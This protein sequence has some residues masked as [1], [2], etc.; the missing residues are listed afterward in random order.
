M[1]RLSIILI[2]SATSMAFAKAPVEDEV[3]QG[4]PGQKTAR[5]AKTRAQLYAERCPGV[6]IESTSGNP[7]ACKAADETEISTASVNASV[8]YVLE[9][10]QPVAAGSVQ[11]VSGLTENTTPAALMRS[12]P[13]GG[14]KGDEGG[15]H[16]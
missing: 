4:V 1:K 14:D 16:Q 2:L 7:S 11:Y 6:N 12:A 5:G 10:R 8:P 15:G 9:P 3:M 13:V